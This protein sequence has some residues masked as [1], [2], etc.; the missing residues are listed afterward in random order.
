MR[1]HIFWNLQCLL[2]KLLEGFD[3][4]NSTLCKSGHLN[5]YCIDHYTLS[6][7]PKFNSLFLKINFSLISNDVINEIT[8]SQKRNVLIQNFCTKSELKEQ[9]FWKQQKAK[10]LTQLVHFNVLSQIF[11]LISCQFWL[12]YKNDLRK[13]FPRYCHMKSVMSFLKYHVY[14]LTITHPSILGKYES[15]W[16]YTLIGTSTVLTFIMAESMVFCAFIDI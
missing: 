2:S 1:F 14:L 4:K 13:T 11:L 8:T 5:C 6:R 7:Y 16:T 9:S 15:I 12:T 3:E 10:I